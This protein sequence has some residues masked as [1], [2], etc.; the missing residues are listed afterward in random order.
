MNHRMLFF[1]SL[2]VIAVG[3][4]GIFLQKK[5]SSLPSA[6][7]LNTSSDK[8]SIFIAEATRDLNHYEILNASGYR[9]REIEIDKD[10]Q[11]I[12]EL[13]LNNS[14]R[15]NGSLVR[16]N[17]AKGSAIIPEMIESPESKTFIQNSLKQ[18]EF[19]YAVHL[20]TD[21]SY[22]LSTLNIGEK[23]SLFLRI[24]E[25]NTAKTINF[26]LGNEDSST[27]KEN[28]RYVISKLMDSVDVINIKR[29]KRSE[30]PSLN[31]NAPIGEVLLRLSLP[32]LTKL[33]VVEKSGELLIFPSQ[34]NDENLNK[35]ITL[36]EVLPQF[37]AVRELRGNK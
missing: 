9:L 24:E 35:K 4:T 27:T 11:D 22:L 16:N 32:Q 31:D 26:K 21:D 37:H 28:K 12:R 3:I 29:Y 17:I 8:R 19:P 25:D 5:G 1:T 6:E 15:L 34:G 30:N 10:A 13:P 33:K 14:G 7:K 20:S 18:S 23:V 36:S 2:I